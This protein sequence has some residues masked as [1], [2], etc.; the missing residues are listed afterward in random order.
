ML[1]REYVNRLRSDGVHMQP[2]SPVYELHTL[3][4]RSHRKLAILD[5]LVGYSGGLNMTEKHLT[6]PN[7]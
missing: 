7:G 2:F 3:S 4:Y 5:G 6:G 1:K